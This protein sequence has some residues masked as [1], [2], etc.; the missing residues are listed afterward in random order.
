MT[1][2]FTS[3]WRDELPATYTAL[4]PTPLSHARPGIGAVMDGLVVVSARGSGGRGGA[5]WSGGGRR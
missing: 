1:L 4:S 5:L 2:S 3:R